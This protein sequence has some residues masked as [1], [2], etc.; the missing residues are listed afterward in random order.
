MRFQYALIEAI[1]KAKTRDAVLAALDHALDM[2]RLCRSDDIGV[3]DCVPAVCLR[4][5]RDQEAYN[6]C[7]WKVTEGSR[8]ADV[9][10]DVREF[11]GKYPEPGRIIPVKLV[12]I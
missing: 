8:N 1:L 3:R 5:E 2:L 12:K 10:E 6:F 11:H 4:L 7:Q 9:F